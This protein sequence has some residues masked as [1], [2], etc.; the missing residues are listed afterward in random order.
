MKPQIVSSYDG[1]AHNRDVPQTS[2]R[3]LKEGAY[4][5][6]STVIVIPAFGQIP[7]KAVAAWWNL[8]TP[9][10]QK[11]AKLF[12]VGMEV[13]EAYSQT[14]QSILD[15][16]ELSKWKYILTMEHDNVPPPDGL[17]RLLETAEAHPEYAAVGGLY[18][19]KGCGGVAQIW[20]DPND[21]PLNFRPLPPVVDQLVECNGTGMGFTLFRM[22]LFK[23]QKLRRPW[24]KTGTGVNEGVF[25]QDLY[26]WTDF[27]KH[28]YRCAID[29]RVKVGHY[30]LNE[31]IT[32]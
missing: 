3:L 31:D 6:L 13:G 19:T 24:F 17:I 21:M 5:D 4:K 18:F 27:K 14:V 2:V 23:D 20:G 26:A 32:W 11:I 10:N 1:G 25:T 22:S 15:N 12:A 7:T 8:I 30:D 16:P 29:C 9:P 28:G